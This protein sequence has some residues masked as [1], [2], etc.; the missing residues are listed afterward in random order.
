MQT[1]VI[2]VALY[3]DKSKCYINLVFYNIFLW[4]YHFDL[5]ILRCICTIIILFF[6]LMLWFRQTAITPVFP[7]K[8]FN[9]YLRVLYLCYILY[10]IQQ[11]NELRTCSTAVYNKNYLFNI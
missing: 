8:F 5:C 1:W 10:N 2:R 3:C 9:T 4:Y 6:D 11:Y 7:G